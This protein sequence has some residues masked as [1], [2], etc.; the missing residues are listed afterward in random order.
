MYIVFQQR[1]VDTAFCCDVS[2]A[3]TYSHPQSQ[4]THAHTYIHRCICDNRAEIKRQNERECV[5]DLLHSRFVWDVLYHHTNHLGSGII[6]LWKTR[7]F[8]L[9][10]SLFYA[11]THVSPYRGDIAW[12]SRGKL[13][14][15]HPPMRTTPR[16]VARISGHTTPLFNTV[17]NSR[18]KSYTQYEQEA[19]D[20]SIKPALGRDPTATQ[21]SRPWW[22]NC[23]VYGNQ[24]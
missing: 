14:L 13:T 24:E 21:I 19:G 5:R 12:L 20:V 6:R 2:H 8:H 17:V 3:S 23:S 16:P 15:F 10:S 22:R 1:L 4:S 18:F 7:T 11:H 9:L